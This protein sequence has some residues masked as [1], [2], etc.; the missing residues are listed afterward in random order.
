MQ[1]QSKQTSPPNPK[2]TK[3]FQLCISIYITTYTFND[4]S[5]SVGLLDGISDSKEMNLGRHQEIKRDRESWLAARSP[6]DR[7]E[8]DTELN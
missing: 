4:S 2:Q 3:K 6:W 5:I 8:S 1:Y 7:K